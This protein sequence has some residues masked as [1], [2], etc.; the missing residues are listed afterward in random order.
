M[1]SSDPRPHVLPTRGCRAVLAGA[2][3]LTLGVLGGCSGAQGGDDTVAGQAK[4]VA[5]R[6]YVSG[7]GRIEKLS[8][9]DRGEPVT[10]TG[11]TLDGQAWSSVDH[12]DKIVVLNVWGSWCPP[13]VAEM[14]ELQKAHATLEKT[15]K[16]VEFMGVDVNEAPET[17]AAFMRRVG[18]TY[19]SLADDGGA[20]LTALQD[21]ASTPPAT[22]LLDR[23]GRIAAR[24]TGET[25]SATVTGLVDDL[26]AEG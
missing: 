2:A 14:P 1:S 13:C 6:A 22:I 7:D 10:L 21:K 15:K 20:A 19:P 5:D 8:A 23:Q 26:L 24:V 9:A 25:T 4:E 18:T 11:K 17:A 3:A 16:P 12:R